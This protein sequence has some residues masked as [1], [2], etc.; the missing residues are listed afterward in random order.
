MRNL[1]Y[2]SLFSSAGIGCYGF[3][4]EGF[5]CIVTNELI[6]R[7][8]DIQRYNHKC[9]YDSGY[10]VGDISSSDIQQKILSEINQWKSIGDREIDVLIAT[11][12]CQGMSVANH[13]KNDEEIT[14]NS[15]VVESIKIIKEVNPL[16]FI[17]ENVPAFLKTICTDIDGVNKTIDSVIKGHLGKHYTVSSNIINFK[18]Y[19]ACSSRARTI[20]IGV[21]NDLSEDITPIELFPEI[22]PEK[23]LREV[24]G[25]LPPL[26]DMG[27]ISPNDIY[28]SFRPYPEY[29]RKWI[30]GIPE[31]TS[32]FDNADPAKRPHQIIDGIMVPNK[33]KNGDKYRRQYWDKVGPCVHT[34]NDLLAS[35]N[36]IHPA[37]D[38]VFS[39]REL[40]LMMTIPDT[41]QWTEKSLAELNAM[42]ELEKKNFLKKNETNIRQSIGEAVP[43]VIFASIAKKIRRALLKK[44][45]NRNDIISKIANFQLSDTN[46]LIQYI[47]SNPENLNL[48]A[49]SRIAELANINRQDNAAYF[50]NKHLANEVIE[51]L[52]NLDGRS[53]RILEPSV[54]VGNFLPFLFK[55]YENAS[56]VRLDVIDIDNNA[57]K[58]LEEL[59]KHMEVPANFTIR[60]ICDDFLL[61]NFEDRYDLVVGNPPY[62]KLSRSNSLCAQ[63]LQNAKNKETTNTCSFFM[64]KA[65]KL[66]NFVALIMPKYF[67]NTSEF[68]RTRE[69]IQ[70]HN[71]SFIIDFGEKGFEGV[72]IETVC[73]GINTTLL[74]HKTI[75]RSITKNTT[76]TQNQYYIT[77]REFPYWILYR[78]AFFDSIAQTMSFGIF[79]VFRDRQITNSLLSDHNSIRVL[80]SRNISDDGKTVLNI[81][82]YDAFLDDNTAKKLSVY[83]YYDRTDVY[84]VPNMTYYPRMMKKPFHC[85]TNGSIA[86]LTLKDGEPPFSEKE[87][88][89]F[90]SDEYRKFYMI[91]RNLQ[92]RSLNID[93]S[94]VFFFGRK[95]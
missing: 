41:F 44:K 65:L 42:T 69:I 29:M 17:F 19:G 58:V 83:S 11:P 72:L 82:G 5:D 12:P 71:I 77:D 76:I 86:I 25:H 51:M 32:A 6:P 40:M 63:Y 94:S 91:A 1:S 62:T 81:Q 92:T 50:T 49:L 53:I 30:A 2:V 4:K 9:L 18:D 55:K 36:T 67:I 23:T 13:K 84:L 93:S 85:V 48:F 54:G 7:R 22:S 45:I 46:N 35:Q 8:M 24:I 89:Y 43:T 61:H 73:I 14:R 57:L 88:A 95:Q 39:I 66:S 87:M 70:G 78:D 26:K 15:L 3:K 47:R 60:M 38:R 56:F 27:E 52:P 10:I 75:V 68:K 37:D 74:P 90:S 64:E 79:T 28:H 16:I 21:R 80:K 20:V 59:L 33:Q 34:R 31:G